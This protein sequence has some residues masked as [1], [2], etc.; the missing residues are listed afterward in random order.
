MQEKPEVDYRRCLSMKSL[1]LAFYSRSNLQ[2]DKPWELCLP[3]RWKLCA[4]QDCL[5][6]LQTESCISVGSR[7]Q[8][9]L[10]TVEELKV[11]SVSVSTETVG[12]LRITSRKQGDSRKPLRAERIVHNPFR[13]YLNPTVQGFGVGIIA[14]S[15]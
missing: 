11:M 10:R 3:R 13:G 6:H 8:V 9:I 2:S 5:L 14:L 4:W 12:S 15:D 7:R 1:L